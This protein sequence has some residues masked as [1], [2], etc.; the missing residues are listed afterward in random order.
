LTSVPK[1]KYAFPMTSNQEFG[2]DNDGELF[3]KFRPKYAYNKNS[4]PEVKYADNY[5]TMT[6]RSPYANKRAET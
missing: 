1:K 5:V 2:W 6:K 3:E 4:C